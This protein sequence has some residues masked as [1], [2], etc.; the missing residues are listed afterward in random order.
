[1]KSKIIRVKHLFITIFCSV[2]I[3]SSTLC[4]HSFIFKY[5]RY[6][7]NHEIVYDSN[8]KILSWMTPQEQSFH[9]TVEIAWN[10]V[11]NK[12][13]IEPSGYK[14]YMISCSFDIF[15][16]PGYATYNDLDMAGL[17]GEFVDSLIPYY[18]YTGD[19]SYVE[20]VR[21]MLDHALMYGLTPENWEWPNMPYAWSPGGD[22]IYSGRIEPDKAGE[23]GLGLL[24]FYHLTG[25][26]E[27]LNAALR[28]ADVLAN[29]VRQ[30]NIHQAPWPFRVSPENGEILAQYTGNVVGELNFLDELIDLSLGNIS[31]YQRARDIARSFLLEHVIPNN[32]WRYYFEDYGDDVPT[33]SEFNADETV[34][35]L[36]N[37]RDWDPNW[38]SH[39]LSIWKWVEDILGEHAWDEYGVLPISEQTVDLYFGE[40]S[41]TARH[42]SVK[43]QYSAITGDENF[44]DAAFRLFNWATYGV[45]EET[46]FI[47]FSANNLDNTEIWYTDGYADF[48]RHFMTG[49]GYI[50]EWSEPGSTHLVRS[51]SIVQN[52]IYAQNNIQYITFDAKAPSIDVFRLNFLPSKIQAGSS[53]LTLQSNLN[54]SGYTLSTLE[55]GDYILTIRH[56]GEKVIKIVE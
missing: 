15:N 52:I 35:Y 17:F 41:H 23:F 54:C 51:S 18:A 38:Q 20:V 34:R 33:K 9:D 24:K 44:K 14:G 6:L 8:G 56:D 40:F 21:E 16:N 45:Q 11:K 27:Y 50:P 49:I 47:I 46:G 3:L 12:V 39:V 32:D 13:P 25:D 2:I 55:N 37:N 53:S 43:A 48:I 30:G 36:L 22:H 28:I 42:A 29:T 19:W 1:M 26:V 4:I 7:G 5:P 10:F 31:G